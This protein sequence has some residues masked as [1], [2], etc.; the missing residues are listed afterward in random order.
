MFQEQICLFR[1]IR[2]QKGREDCTAQRQVAV[3]VDVKQK[4][5]EKKDEVCV[6]LEDRK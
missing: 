3:P 5:K 4:E 1:N 2:R 6:N